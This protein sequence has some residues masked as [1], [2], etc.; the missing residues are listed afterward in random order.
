MWRG[1]KTRSGKWATVLLRN[2]EEKAELEKDMEKVWLERL[3]R[4]EEKSDRRRQFNMVGRVHYAL[5][6][7][8]PCASEGECHFTRMGLRGTTKEGIKAVALLTLAVIR[9]TS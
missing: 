3:G 4:Q 7:P 2:Q 6:L 1:R 5:P 9:N 8:P